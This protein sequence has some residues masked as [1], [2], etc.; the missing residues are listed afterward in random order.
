MK[1][2]NVGL[3]S[4]TLEEAINFSLIN[5]FRTDQYFVK[6]IIG[7][8]SDDLIP[9]FYGF[10]LNSKARFY[11]FGM[12]PREIVIRLVLR[13]R[14]HLDESYSDVRDELYRA[15]SATRTGAVVLHFNAGATTVSRIQGFITKFEVPYFNKEPEVQ[16][17]ITCD[18]PMFRS[19]N[20]IYYEPEDLKTTNP[21]LIGD[22]L[23][24]APHGF[25]MEVTLKANIPSFTIQDKQTDPEWRFRIIPSGGFLI[26]DVL[27][28]SSEHSD[29]SLHIVRSGST[30]PLVDKIEPGSMWPIIFP[31]TNDFH[32]VDIASFDWVSLEYYAAYWGV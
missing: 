18:D 15:I 23:S 21:I 16:L 7:L 28:I 24:T 30:I 6:N 10:A 14:F 17:T 11:D 32:F 9:K 27:H 26:G 29:K 19:I 2:T 13:P 22:S 5:P 1:V 12:K 8:D 31:G 20:S 25:V 3:Y 4:P